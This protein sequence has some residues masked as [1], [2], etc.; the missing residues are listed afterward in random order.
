ME[1]H[2]NS[3]SRIQTVLYGEMEESMSEIVTAEK[4]RE[5]SEGQ[6]LKNLN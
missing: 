1:Q 5:H 3:I 6:S 2:Q 4:R